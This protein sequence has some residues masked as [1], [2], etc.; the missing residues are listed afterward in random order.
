MRNP[1]EFL[2]SQYGAFE[3]ESQALADLV[4]D[5]LRRV[6]GLEARE[7]QKAQGPNS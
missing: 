5:L 4:L 1:K 3:P 7:S 2:E 6:E